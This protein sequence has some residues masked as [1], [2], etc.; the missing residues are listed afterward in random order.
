MSNGPL[1]LHRVEIELREIARERDGSRLRERLGNLEL[2]DQGPPDVVLERSL[3][4][5]LHG[6]PAAAADLRP[7]RRRR[8]EPAD[9]DLLAQ[10]SVHVDAQPEMPEAGVGVAEELLVNEQEVAV[11]VG[12]PFSLGALDLLKA[13]VAHALLPNRSLL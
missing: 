13:F 8:G 11:W 5:R 9:I 12:P 4:G 7:A 10:L 1:A 2:V 3:V 6:P